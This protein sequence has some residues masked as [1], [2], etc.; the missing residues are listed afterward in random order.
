MIV[1]T[2]QPHVAEH[3]DEALVTAAGVT[4]ELPTRA[5]D[6]GTL[7]IGVIGVEQPFEGLPSDAESAAPGGDLETFEVRAGV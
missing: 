4:S 6:R 2:P 3:R 1:G 7:E 5:R